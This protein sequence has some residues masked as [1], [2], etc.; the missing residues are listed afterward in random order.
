MTVGD[1]QGLFKQHIGP[2]DIF[3]EMAGGR[4]GEEMHADFWK[5]M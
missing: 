1:H 2:I 3:E 5:K 4:G